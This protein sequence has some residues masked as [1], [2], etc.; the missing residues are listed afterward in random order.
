MSSIESHLSNKPK[1]VFFNPIN[2]FDT[3]T[4]SITLLYIFHKL[5]SFNVNF[6]NLQIQKYWNAS[7]EQILSLVEQLS[8]ALKDEFKQCLPK[9]IPLLISALGSKIGGSI[10]SQDQTN[11]N[12]MNNSSHLTSNT[13]SINDY[14]R[15]GSKDQITT[16]RN[17]RV[18]ED[19]RDL[20]R[21]SG[22]TRN[23][24]LNRIRMARASKNT[25]K[26]LHAL[27]VLGANLLDH[28]HLIVPSLLYLV[29]SDGM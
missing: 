11:R 27:V 18:S 19:P 25:I 17:V 12:S 9:L 21:A 7:T 20:G 14:N 26:G 16:N 24:S 29:E 3:F 1:Q 6:F 15:R 10:S 23:Q 4:H 28:L 22:A 5:F 8:R 2:I 13:N